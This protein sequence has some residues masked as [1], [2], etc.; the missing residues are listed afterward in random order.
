M[1]KATPQQQWMITFI[2]L[3]VL[4][5]S[6]IL[7]AVIEEGVMQVIYVMLGALLSSSFGFL[8]YSFF[9]KK[10]KKSK[11]IG[12]GVE[13]LVGIL[14]I[15]L[16]VPRNTSEEVNIGADW[17]MQMFDEIAFYTPDSLK[18]ESEISSAIYTVYSNKDADRLIVYVGLEL[19]S[20]MPSN[21]QQYYDDIFDLLVNKY[22]L[23][24]EILSLSNGAD[25]SSQ[26]SVSNIIKMNS[27]GENRLGYGYVR[28]G[29]RKVESVW[30]LPLTISFEE[31]FI[32]EF[33]SEI[34][35]I[36]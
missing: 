32:Q 36:I 24:Y 28:M 35:G 13:V 29:N 8:M 15:A 18:L 16:F 2:G 12:I 3:P 4:F 23:N 17:R 31:E 27:S 33:K 34:Y 26:S 19:D 7:K 5:S 9:G 6:L 10:S 30:L 11:I 20:T 14:A 21:S 1:S 22:N 25:E